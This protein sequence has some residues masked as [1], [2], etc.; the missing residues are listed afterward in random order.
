MY[1]KDTVDVKMY[2]LSISELIIFDSD[3]TR[4]SSTLTTQ[5]LATVIERNENSHS[6]NNSKQKQNQRLEPI[7]VVIRLT[8]LY[9][10]TATETNVIRLINENLETSSKANVIRL[11]SENLKTTTEI[12]VIG[13]VIREPEYSDQKQ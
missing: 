13:I 3:E 5:N 9:L 2:Y 12:N 7:I 8:T 6:A 1:E 4:P 10:K 11:I